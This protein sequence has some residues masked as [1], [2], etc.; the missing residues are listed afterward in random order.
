MARAFDAQVM[1]LRVL[2]CPVSTAQQGHAIDLFEWQM[3]KAEAEAYLNATAARLQ[4]ADLQVDYALLE[5]QPAPQILDCVR[6]HDIDLIVL[7]S[8]GESGLTG[9]NVSSVVQK[10][11]L[12]AHVSILLVRAY[13][14]QEDDLVSLS[15]RRLLVPLNGSQ[16][17]ECIL[18]PA[19]IL[20][21]RYNA[22]L[23]LT[24]V[25][26][27]PYIFHHGLPNGVADTAL[28]EQLTEHNR[29]AAF[30]YFEQLRS[31]LDGD[32]RSHILVGE[33]VAIQLHRFAEEEGVDLVVMCAHGYSGHRKWPYGSVA[34]SFIQYGL[35]PLLIIQDLA[36]DEVET[37]HA[38]RVSQ[39][40]RGH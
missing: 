38:E 7:S 1:L 6:H 35:T 28:A 19:S 21:R 31:H 32:V 15:Y 20:A 10:V 22:Q 18:A 8:H 26:P 34:A 25:V 29:Q 39:E 27:K 16:R 17:A 33:D 40:H 24:H 9:W 14:Q 3:C 36:P 2:V 5:G 13:G 11:L 37:T 12:R 23:L 4:E 30:A